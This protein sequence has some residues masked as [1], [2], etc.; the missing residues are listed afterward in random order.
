MY[1]A[2]KEF[3]KGQDERF[4][5]INEQH[6]RLQKLIADQ[7]ALLQEIENVKKQVTIKIAN[8]LQNEQ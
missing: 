7:N 6:G 5:Q 8:G 3:E 1:A 2:D 4:N